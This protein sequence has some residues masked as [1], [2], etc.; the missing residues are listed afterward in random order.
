MVVRRLQ[1]A[2][3]EGVKSIVH[4]VGYRPGMST[5]TVISTVKEAVWVAANWGRPI[6]VASLDI[7]ECF[8]FMCIQR[9]VAA[10]QCA[11]SGPAGA[12]RELLCHRRSAATR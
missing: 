7:K 2:E 10:L 6:V 4:T 3:R 12:E 8:D 1:V 11:L 5:A 9:V